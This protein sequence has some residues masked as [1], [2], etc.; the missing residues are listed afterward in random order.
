MHI[1]A[2]PASMKRGVRPIVTRRGARDAMDANALSDV[3]CASGRQRRV[4]LAPQWQVPACASDDVSPS[5]S[6]RRDAHAAVTQKP[7]SPGRARRSLLKPSRRECRCFGFICGDYT[8]VLSTLHTRLRVQPN[9]RHSLR[10]LVYLG[11]SEAKARAFFV[12][13]TRTHI[14]N[15]HAPRRRGIQYSDRADGFRV[16]WIARSCTQLRTRRA[17]TPNKKAAV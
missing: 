7:V 17:M 10:P 9:T 11:V 5:G 14:L 13:G 4:G 3:Q 8:R 1:C 15:C 16:Y 12:A 6:T 2:C